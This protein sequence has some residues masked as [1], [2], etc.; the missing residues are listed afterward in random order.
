[1][2]VQLVILVDINEDEKLRK[3]YQQTPGSLSRVAKLLKDYGNAKGK[4]AH[5]QGESE[6]GESETEEEIESDKSIKQHI[7][8]ED[9]VGPITVN[10]EFWEPGPSGPQK[11]GSSLVSYL[12]IH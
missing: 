11:R 2:D 1:M 9:W 8:V 7:V 3:T 4:A 10:L 5:Q 6:T 12:L